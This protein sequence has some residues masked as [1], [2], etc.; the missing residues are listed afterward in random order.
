[1]KVFAMLLVAI[2]DKIFFCARKPM[3]RA[4]KALSVMTEMGNEIMLFR[5]L[6]I[7]GNLYNYSQTFRRDKVD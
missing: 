3:S 6:K 2:R 7:K 4:L 1:M 5:Y